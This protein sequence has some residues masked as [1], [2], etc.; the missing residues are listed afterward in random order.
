MLI[1]AFIRTS[2]VPT[3]YTKAA[4][5]SQ[6]GE[7]E[8]INIS[9]GF[10]TAP[11]AYGW[12]LYLPSGQKHLWKR[13]QAWRALMIFV[14]PSPKKQLVFDVS[15]HDECLTQ[16]RYPAIS[17]FSS[18]KSQISCSTSLIRSMSRILVG[19]N[20]SSPCL[21]SCHPTFIVPIPP[22]A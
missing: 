14:G 17:S 18:C 12:T 1:L 3:C 4:F 6:A 21:Q 20:P 8:I 10:A 7:E 19:R 16:S 9:G 22:N 13:A 11:I 15:Y 5:G 2:L